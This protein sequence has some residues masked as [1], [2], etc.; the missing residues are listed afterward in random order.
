MRFRRRDHGTAGRQRFD[1]DIWKPLAAGAEYAHIEEL[2]Q[3][4]RLDQLPREMYLS[5]HVQLPG[6]LL[7]LA[8]RRSRAD[9]HQVH[10]VVQTLQRAQ[11]HGVIL[12][13]RETGHGADDEG[14]LRNTPIAAPGAAHPDGDVT[15]GA[16]LQEIGHLEDARRR[17][18]LL[19]DE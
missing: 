1:D 17:H 18:G 7:E 16:L 19:I 8:S 2:M 10:I 12:H 6:Q 3:I 14:A 9:Q 5:L 11:R 15:K 4:F 13:R